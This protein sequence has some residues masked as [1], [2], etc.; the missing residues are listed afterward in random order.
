VAE[1]LALAANVGRG[2]PLRRPTKPRPPPPPPSTARPG[3]ASSEKAA[4]A[5]VM[6]GAGAERGRGGA[7]GAV[8]DMLAL[9]CE[10][11]PCQ[12]GGECV[13]DTFSARGFTCRCAEGHYGEICEYGQSLHVLRRHQSA[14]LN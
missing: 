14:Q 12:H 8:K 7:A 6:S 2:P 1:A 13:S 4:A 5:R 3:R 10:A 11:V 9:G